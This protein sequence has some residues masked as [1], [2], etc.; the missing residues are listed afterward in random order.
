LLA[1]AGVP[2]AP[3]L[4]FADTPDGIQLI[5]VD[6]E[7]VIETADRGRPRVRAFDTRAWGHRDIEPNWPISGSYLRARVTLPGLRYITDPTVPAGRGTKKL[8]GQR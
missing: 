7:Y 3:S 8:G 1:G 2:I 4:T 6:P 5:Q